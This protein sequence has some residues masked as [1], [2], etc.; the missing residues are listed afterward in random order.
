MILLVFSSG[1]CQDPETTV[2]R[3]LPDVCIVALGLSATIVVPHRF[4][5]SKNRHRSLINTRPASC[6]KNSGLVYI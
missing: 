6:E 1:R 5:N 4:N 2:H 3:V